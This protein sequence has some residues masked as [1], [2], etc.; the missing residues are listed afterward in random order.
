M[1]ISYQ[2]KDDKV[3][4]VALKVQEL[5]LKLSDVG[6]IALGAGT[7][8]VIQVGE[9]VSQVRSVVHCDDSVGLVLIAQ[10]GIAVSGSQITV[11]LSNAMAANDSLIVKYVVAE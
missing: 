7:D 11:T 10:A 9:P 4:S 2:S 8:V 6:V 1:S 3:L 5:C